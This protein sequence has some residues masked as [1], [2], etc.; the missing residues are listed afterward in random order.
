MKKVLSLL[1]VLG[2]LLTCCA[3]FSSCDEVSVK[4]VEKDP[5]AAIND[6]TSNSL[7]GFFSDDA[8]MGKIIAAAL[9]DGSVSIDFEGS[10][11]VFGMDIDLNETIY[12]DQK[13]NKYVSD[14][15]L[16]MAE[17]DIAAR[18]FLDKNGFAFNSSAL[19]GSNKTLLVDFATLAANFNNSAL[20]EMLLGEEA[21]ADSLEEISKMLNLLKDEYAKLFS[22]QN[23]E[24]AEKFVNELYALLNQTVTEGK[25][26]KGDKEVG[27]IIVSY[28]INNDTIKALLN[29]LAEEMNSEFSKLSDTFGES[30]DVA[31]GGVDVEEYINQI[32]ASLD[33]MV[34]ID[35]AEQI[36]LN[37]KTNALEK[38]AINGSITPKGDFGSNEANTVALDVLFDKNEI[39]L[40]GNI[41][42]NGDKLSFDAKLAKET[43][44]DTIQYV[45]SVNVGDGKGATVNALNAT[46]EYNKDNGNLKLSADVY[47]DDDERIT[48]ELNGSIKVTKNDAK[49]Q[50]TSLKYMDTTWSF[51]FA[52]TF[53]KSAEMPELPSDTKDIVNMSQEEW[54]ALAS[55]IIQNGILGMFFQGSFAPDDEYIGDIGGNGDIGGIGDYGEFGDF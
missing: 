23:Q 1:L 13:D 16:K 21:D 30:F 41:V 22:A 31:L 39:S 20:K 15:T 28:T 40:V 50:F 14:T 11:D 44:D 49:I 2:M 10:K 37:K 32:T 18:I 25:L 5:V 54:E 24:D 33:Q 48:V 12:F 38:M 45:L 42:F 9:K 4:D 8:D 3:F 35:L 27:C 51:N 6:A 17:Q 53:N 47:T 26:T 7:D 19:L 34:T 36:Y 52:V 55:E 43:K 29:K 46:Y